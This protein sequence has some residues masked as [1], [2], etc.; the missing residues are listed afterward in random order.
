MVANP[1]GLA[2]HPTNFNSSKS[3]SPTKLNLLYNLSP[4]VHRNNIHTNS[5]PQNQ[6]TSFSHANHK[7]PTLQIYTYSFTRVMRTCITTHGIRQLELN[8]LN[9]YITAFIANQHTK[10]TTHHKTKAHHVIDVKQTTQKIFS[11]TELLKHMLAKQ[12]LIPQTA[13]NYNS[14]TS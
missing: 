3:E 4:Q 1:V 11:N 7:S 10:Q 6:N 14:T 2:R 13:A 5:Q 9:A 8:N 12:Q